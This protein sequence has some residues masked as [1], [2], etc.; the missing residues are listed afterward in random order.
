[1]KKALFSFLILVSLSTNISAMFLFNPLY[2]G[3]CSVYECLTQDEQVDTYQEPA[4][5]QY[6]QDQE[7]DKSLIKNNSLRNGI[8]YMQLKTVDQFD[9]NV[10]F[11][12]KQK[13]QSMVGVDMSWC[14]CRRY[15]SEH[16]VGAHAIRHAVF[17]DTF[18]SEVQDLHDIANRDLARDFFK[19]FIK[20]N[21][22]VSY[23]TFNEIREIIAHK[24]FDLADRVTCLESLLDLEDPEQ[25]E[26]KQ[27]IQERFKNRESYYHIFIMDIDDFIPGVFNYLYQKDAINRMMSFR[28]SIREQV[29]YVVAL[30]KKGNKR[31]CYIINLIDRLDHI[32]DISYSLR[33][34]FLAETFFYG[35]SLI[36]YSSMCEKL[37]KF[38]ITKNIINI[39]EKNILEIVPNR[40][41]DGIDQIA[42]YITYC[43]TDLRKIFATKVCKDTIMYMIYDVMRSEKVEKYKKEAFLY[44][45]SQKYNIKLSIQDFNKSFIKFICILFKQVP[46]TS[47][48]SFKNRRRSILEDGSQDID[49]IERAGFMLDIL[50]APDENISKKELVI[51]EKV[52][53]QKKFEVPTFLF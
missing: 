35:S 45:I 50:D 5:G 21:F 14:W 41:Q 49:H 51:G 33:D 40:F 43:D 13:Y 7:E 47:K 3:I 44:E 20:Q 15:N 11:Y 19:N 8:S 39:S 34:R 16:T 4:L 27:A 2:R 10:H 9:K 12:I 37:A 31:N 36:N 24:Y 29:S 17:L 38:F 46:E 22:A 53:R 25:L 48:K 52:G 42:E 6:G 26:I 32:D 30:E 28:K 23:L 1:M 18:L